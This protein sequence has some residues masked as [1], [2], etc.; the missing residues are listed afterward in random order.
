MKTAPCPWVYGGSALGGLLLGTFL[1]RTG[2]SDYRQVHE[3]WV[4]RDLRLIFV[5]AFGLFLTAVGFQLL[6]DDERLPSKKLHKGII[7]GGILF[8]FGWFLT[9]ACPAVP[10]AQIGEGKGLA[11][12]TLAG[13]LL[14]TK[15]YKSVHAQW[16]GWDK[17]S[18]EA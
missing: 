13:V 1:H 5:F 16:F 6:Q 10:L 14:G 2:F 7:P 9:G 12:V 8:G 3:M 4:L 18:C 11:F 17:G 15:F